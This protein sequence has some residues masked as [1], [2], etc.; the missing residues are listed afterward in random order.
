MDKENEMM[1]ILAIFVWTLGDIVKASV[2]GLF[3]SLLLI[4]GII[5]GGA[6]LLDRWTWWRIKRNRSKKS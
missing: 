4:V 5:Y 2:L 3:I 1:P 6:C